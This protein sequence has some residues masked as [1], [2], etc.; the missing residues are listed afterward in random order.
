[1]ALTRSVSAND[2]VEAC[3]E[4]QISRLEDREIPDSERLKHQLALPPPKRTS[5]SIACGN[6]AA[7]VPGHGNDGF[8]RLP[9]PFGGVR[10]GRGASSVPGTGIFELLV[11]TGVSERRIIRD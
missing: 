9:S 2:D 4:C 6:H 10:G 3:G 5:P 8:S 1:M 11:N 7:R